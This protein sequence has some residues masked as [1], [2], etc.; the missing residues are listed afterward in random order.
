[1]SS[2]G[3]LVERLARFVSRDFRFLR[4]ECPRVEL[5]GDRDRNLAMALPCPTFLIERSER[6]Y[7]IGERRLHV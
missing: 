2:P 6:R 7:C 1:M 3:L 4:V 5:S